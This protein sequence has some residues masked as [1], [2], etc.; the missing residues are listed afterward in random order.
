MSEPWAV[1][2]DAP[3]LRGLDEAARRTLAAAARVRSLQAGDVVFGEQDPADAFY[4]VLDGAVELRAQRRGDEGRSRLR[5]AGPGDTF[6]EEALSGDEQTGRRGQ[7]IARDRDL[8]G[9]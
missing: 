7:A 4:V 2:W 6:G 8:C 1:L 9:R 3:V 5:T